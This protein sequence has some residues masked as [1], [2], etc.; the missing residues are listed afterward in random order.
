MERIIRA[1]AGSFVTISLI[2]G[3]F[4]S[5]YWYLFTLF[6]GLNLFQSAFTKWCLAEEIL[7]K[8]GIGVPCTTEG[9]SKSELEH[10]T[11]KL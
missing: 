10:Q 6:V 7:K 11:Q 2:L 5:P 4:V 8:F 1:V 3:Y 9:N